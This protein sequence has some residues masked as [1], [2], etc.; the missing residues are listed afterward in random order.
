MTGLALDAL[1]AIGAHNLSQRLRKL[2]TR[3][4]S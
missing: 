3:W 4:M 2:H 1:P